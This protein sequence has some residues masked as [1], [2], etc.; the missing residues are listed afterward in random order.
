MPTPVHRRRSALQWE[1]AVVPAED[2]NVRVRVYRP[3][4]R[5][6]GWLVW[7]H[8]GSWTRGSVD[9][10][11]FAC[12]DLARLATCT[13]V[14]VEY[15]LAPR[16]PHPAA[17]DDVLAVLDWAGA[18]AEREGMGDRL[19][20][21][22][23]SAGGTIAACAAL[24][25]RDLRRPLA[26]QLLAYPPLDPWCRSPSYFR[27][28]NSFPTRQAMISAWRTYLGTDWRRDTGSAYSTPFEAADLRGV[29]P[30]ALGVGE[31]D[32]VADDVRLYERRLLASGNTVELRSFPDMGHGAFLQPGTR[33]AVDGS[34]QRNPLLAWFG[35]AFRELVAGPAEQ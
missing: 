14:S 3:K 10:W 12:A 31:L 33:I 22:G 7:A 4:G 20:V 5:R 9:G 27:H 15:R 35:S 29:A 18:K 30:A 26:A 24:T 1:E 34:V 28:A 23:D 8:G 16:H 25:W 19:G 32:P 13:L 21:G 17:L 2:R 11:H 6:A